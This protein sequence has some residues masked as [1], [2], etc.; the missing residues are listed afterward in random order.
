M[1]A[2]LPAATLTVRYDA[3]ELRLVNLSTSECPILRIRKCTTRHFKCPTDGVLDKALPLIPY[4]LCPHTTI[5]TPAT[6]SP[7]LAPLRRT[8]AFIA[9][10]QRRAS[11]PPP[12]SLL[13][14]FYADSTSYK[15]NSTNS[16]TAQLGS[17]TN[18]TYSRPT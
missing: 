7:A 15:E 1:L 5:A 4:Q 18:M 10:Q 13:Q 3:V 9:T 6:G 8:T 16:A 2:P 11:H 12:L 17:S 14:H